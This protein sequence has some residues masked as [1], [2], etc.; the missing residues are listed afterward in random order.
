MYQLL[1]TITI[2]VGI[3]AAA[4]ERSSSEFVWTSYYQSVYEKKGYDNRSYVLV[5]GMLTTLY[6]MSGYEAGSQVSEETTD[7]QMSA[8]KSIVHGVLAAIAIGFA[9]FLGLLYAMNNNIHGALN[10]ITSQPVVNIFD[11]AFTD[12]EGNRI[13]A[14]SMTM[15][16]LLLINVYLGGFSHMTVTSRIIFAMS[17]DGALPGSKYIYGVNERLGLPLKSIVMAFVI[18]SLMCLLPLINDTAFDAITGISTIGY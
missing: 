2:I 16:I 11:M 6:G 12:S 13:L 14:G 5:I 10:G 7:A 18:G 8:P 9:F 1:S 3:I 15:A 4:P 17:R